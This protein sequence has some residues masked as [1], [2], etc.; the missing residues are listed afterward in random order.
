MFLIAVLG[1]LALLLPMQTFPR[2][3]RP[4]LPVATM[5]RVAPQGGVASARRVGVE[6]FGPLLGRWR[7]QGRFAASGKPLSSIMTFAVTA[8]GKAI[9]VEAAEEAPNT[10]AYGAL[11]SIGKGGDGLIMTLVAD[12]GDPSLYRSKGW[13]GDRM[14]FEPDHRFGDGPGGDRFTYDRTADEGF[15]ITYEFSRDGR[16]WRVGDRQTFTRIQRVS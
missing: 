1:E 7:G 10:F 4:A 9:S 15:S 13:V 2:P 6:D 14:I 8:G 12:E 11:W 3:M 16:T 5:T